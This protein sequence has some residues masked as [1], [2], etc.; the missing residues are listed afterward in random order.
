MMVTIVV[1]MIDAVT[2]VNT[3]QKIILS[4]HEM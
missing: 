4:S 1:M 3:K 2:E